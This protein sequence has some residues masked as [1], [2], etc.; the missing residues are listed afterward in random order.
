M[1]IRRNLAFLLIL[2]TF[3]SV[4]ASAAPSSPEF[5]VSFPA[6]VHQQSITGRLLLMLSRTNEPE[7][8]LQIGWVNSPPVFGVDVSRFRP[9]QVTV[10]NAQVPGFP[11]RSLQNLPSGDYYV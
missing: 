6:S 4:C 10:I 9:G 8:R 1:I 5:E 11:I 7:V 3:S 2:T